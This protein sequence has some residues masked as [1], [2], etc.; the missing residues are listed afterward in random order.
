MVAL[1]LLGTAATIAIAWGIAVFVSGVFIEKASVDSVAG[2]LIIVALAGLVK[3]LVIW[4]QELLSARAAVS[5]K[6]ELRQKYF[7]AVSK[8]GS[9][10]INNRSIAELNLLA[11]T[12]LDALGPYFSKYLPQ[13]VYTALVTPIFVVV[14]WSQDLG[15]A[16]TLIVTLPLIPLFM[17]LIGWATQTVQQKQLIALTRLSQHFLEALRGLTT[18]KIFRRADA[19][20]NT[21]SV[22]SEQYRVRT[23]KVLRVSFL[24]GFALELLGS[25]SVALIAVSIGLRMV[26]GELSLLVGLFVLLLAPEAYLPIRQ[27]GAH[28][29]AAAEGVTASQAILD[30]IDEAKRAE[31]IAQQNSTSFAPGFA[32]GKL[33]VITGPS[34]AGK[35]SILRGFLGFDGGESAVPIERVAWAPQQHKL[36]PGT[37]R[38]NIVGPLDSNGS[39]DQG[40]LTE[41]MSLAAL[42]ELE[43]DTQ[44]G[45]DAT[46]ISGGQAQRICLARAFYRTLTHDSDYLLLDEPISAIDQQ[47]ASRVVQSLVEFAGA[48]KTVVAISHQQAL[49]DSADSRIEVPSV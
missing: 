9:N 33:T 17:V 26:N 1:A 15:S 16:I 47:R 5:A 3:A 22:A 12:G 44:V 14:V 27:V 18:L 13:L 4:L 42:D 39:I 11:T 38:E 45:V 21:M 6:T 35:T 7:N 36:W 46:E 40:A 30:V 20:V 41:A 48:G 31:S 8:L 23:M 34:G 29:H 32:L 24:S 43:L 28:F 10:W 19:Q 25:L 37:V 49:I 2:N